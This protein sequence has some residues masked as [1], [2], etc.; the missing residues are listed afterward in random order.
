MPLKDQTTRISLPR[1]LDDDVGR[2]FLP[3]LAAAAAEKSVTLDFSPIEFAY[4]LGTLVAGR[5]IHH[6]VLSRRAKKLMTFAS[7]INLA[8]PAHSFLEFIG[9][10]DFAGFANKTKVGAAPG[11]A[12][13]VPIRC[14]KRPAPATTGARAF[15]DAIV[16]QAQPLADVL[17]GCRPDT[18]EHQ[19]IL[20]SL[21]EVIRNVFE[22]S[23]TDECYV[24]A[25]RWTTGEVEVAVVDEGMG[26][27]ASLSAAVPA[28]G[29]AEAIELA[30]QPGVTRTMKLGEDDNLHGNSGFGLYVLAELGR[31]FG[32]FTLGSESAAVV[33]DEG[34]RESRATRF[35]GTFVGL[36]LRKPMFDFGGVLDD[37]V[38]AGEAAAAAAGLTAR[39]SSESRR[40]AGGEERGS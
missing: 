25:Q 5:E 20:Y 8:R 19:A 7:G 27:R 31:C 15:H 38:D 40:P 14:F 18:P 13:Y 23:G 24:A 21:K 17:A 39:A 34:R 36:R 11:S 22:H 32:R 30:L 29:D 10:L 1:Y 35:H 33:I 28:S 2:E 4:P 16:E 12:R 37:I 26:I 9:F 3:A 6:F